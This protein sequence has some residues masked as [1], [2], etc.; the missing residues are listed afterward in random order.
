M[1]TKVVT[2]FRKNNYLV[3]VT[4]DSDPESIILFII[5]GL[6]FNPNIMNINKILNSKNII[7]SL[8][9]RINILSFQNDDF[10]QYQT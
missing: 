2:I 6:G 5:I 3:T 8:Y 9:V 1:M 10:A 4:P 7:Y